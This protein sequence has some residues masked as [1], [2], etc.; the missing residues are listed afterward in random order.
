[1]I[2]VLVSSRGML[3]SPMST[4]VNL[5]W[6]NDVGFLKVI[7]ILTIFIVWSQDDVTK[8]FFCVFDHSTDMISA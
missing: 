7:G 8:V 4:F 5:V 3:L 2:D 6:A 1:M